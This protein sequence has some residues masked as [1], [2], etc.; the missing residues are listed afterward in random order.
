MISQPLQTKAQTFGN[1]SG[2][3]FGQSSATVFGQPIPFSPVTT[4]GQSDEGRPLPFS[5]LVPSGQL[6]P[7]TFGQPQMSGTAY[8]PPQTFGRTSL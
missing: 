7:T 4:F 6:I 1:A 3:T 8:Q 5:K 2:Q